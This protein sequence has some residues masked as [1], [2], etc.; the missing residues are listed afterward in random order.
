[1][2]RHDKSW[3]SRESIGQS[4]I[5][6][7]LRAISISSSGS[8]RPKLMLAHQHRARG[9]WTYLKPRPS[10]ARSRAPG[11]R[12]SS[13]LDIISHPCLGRENRHDGCQRSLEKWSRST[14][15]AR[16][17]T[18]T[19]SESSQAPCARAHRCFQRSMTPSAY[20]SDRPTRWHGYESSAGAGIAHVMP[21]A[22]SVKTEIPKL[23][24]P[25]LKTCP[26]WWEMSD[27]PFAPL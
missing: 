22:A 14:A 21:K 15:C 27:I 16:T 25:E 24:V 12:I 5:W 23:E 2:M 1:M 10:E 7:C 9:A 11:W 20:G 8:L 6:N 4:I 26:F 18:Q 3:V 17:G 19:L 13:D